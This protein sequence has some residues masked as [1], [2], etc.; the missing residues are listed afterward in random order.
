MSDALADSLNAAHR[1]GLRFP[2]TSLI[3][4]ML[5]DIRDCEEAE[6]YVRRHCHSASGYRTATATLPEDATSTDLWRVGGILAAGGTPEEARDNWRLAD[7]WLMGRLAQRIVVSGAECFIAMRD[8]QHR[9]RQ[10]R[11]R[12]RNKRFHAARQA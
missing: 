8:A 5:A 1:I 7:T 12:G 3:D 10:P 2:S 4:A 6:A 11:T 9:S